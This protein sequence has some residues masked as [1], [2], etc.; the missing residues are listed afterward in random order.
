MIS[1][2]APVVPYG[3]V[4]W[5]YD[6]PAVFEHRARHFLAEGLAAGERV[7][8]VATGS[9]ER[10][11]ERLRGSAGFSDALRRGAAQVVTLNETYPGGV[12]DPLGQLQRYAAA[13]D[14]AVAAGY[15]G[16]RVAADAT[17]L[18]RTSAQ[19]A[20]F[21]RY[22]HAVDRYMRIRPLSAMCGYHR[23]ELGDRT[24]AAL[25][26]LHPV[27]NVAEV[28][29]RLYAC[30]PGDGAAALAGELDVFNHEQFA[31]AL[32]HADL[33]PV[34]G[35]LVVGAGELRFIDHHC[36]TRL[37]DYAGGRAATA[38]LR[39]RR[40]AATRLVELLGL[41]GLRVEAVR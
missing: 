11:V 16:L 41:T 37:R 39:T 4:C 40:T 8:Y 2:L 12:V 30:A 5:A 29:F 22:E 3:H 32:E 9:P 26:C 35:E 1:D 38:V 20:A 25:A 13:T 15:A 24:V 6:D 31:T 17:P 10:V 18:V 7:W 21:A 14:E 23:A 34:G 36:L 27:N 33:S 28:L 19:L